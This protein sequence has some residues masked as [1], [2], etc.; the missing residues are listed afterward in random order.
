MAAT[1]ASIMTALLGSVTRPLTDALVD[2]A[3]STSG[4]KNRRN[5]STGTRRIITLLRRIV[6]WKSRYCHFDACQIFSMHLSPFCD[7]DHMQL[8]SL[9]QTFREIIQEP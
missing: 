6:A 9:S 7:P 2:C 3:S 1:F 4:D 8:E 5:M